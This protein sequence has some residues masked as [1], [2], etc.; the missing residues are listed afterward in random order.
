MIGILLGIGLQDTGGLPEVSGI[1][2]VIMICVFVI[3]FAYSWGCMG[4]LIPSETFPLE[5]RSAGLSVVVSVNLL[6]T[7]FM[8]QAFLS[9]LCAMKSTIFLLF[10]FFVLVMSAFVYFFIPETKGIPIEASTVLWREH[11]FWKKVVS[12]KD[13]GESGISNKLLQP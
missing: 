6:F 13:G 7:F 4:W 9:T 2:T 3:A 1:I 8:A 12:I 11:W 5:L 10:A